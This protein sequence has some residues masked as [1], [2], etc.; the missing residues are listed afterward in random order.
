MNRLAIGIF[1]PRDCD[2]ETETAEWVVEKDPLVR[3]I[4]LG[5]QFVL[6][7]IRWTQVTTGAGRLQGRINV[8]V[9]EADPPLRLFVL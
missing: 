6:H 1:G 8:L 4:A 3:R 7:A 2:S 9:D 5:A